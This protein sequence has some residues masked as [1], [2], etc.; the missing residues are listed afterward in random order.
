MPKSNKKAAAKKA[1]A[2]KAA[3]KK[4]AAAKKAAP[5]KKAAAKKAAPVARGAV[6]ADSSIPKWSGLSV[7]R[8]RSKQEKVSRDLMEAI[9]AGDPVRNK[10]LPDTPFTDVKDK[11]GREV[12]TGRHLVSLAGGQNAAQFEKAAKNASLKIASIESFDDLNQKG[13][14]QQILQEADGVILPKLEVAI[15]NPD[16]ESELSMLITH[17]STKDKFHYSE[18]ER[19]VYPAM[20]PKSKFQYSN[21]V[22]SAWGIQVINALNSTFS[23]KGIRIAVLDTGLDLDHPDFAGRIAGSKSFIENEDANDVVGHGSMSAGIAG[24]FRRTPDG[25]RYGVAFG[26]SLYIGKVI[27]KNSKGTDTSLL[28]GIE[29]A[30]QHKC[31]IINLS[32]VRAID[33]KQK[34]YSADYES[35]AAKALQNN[36]LIIAAAGNESDR[37]FNLIEPVAEP[38][39]CPSVMAVAALD[40]NIQVANFSCGGLFANGGQIDIAGPGVDIFSTSKEAGY[41][42]DSGTSA[43]APFVSGL[44]ALF[45]EKHPQATASEIWMKLIQNAKRLDINATDVGAGLA[46][47]L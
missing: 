5:K 7:I 18:P 41:A 44:A 2:K 34:G 30:L 42:T 28:D 17:P 24:G 12:Y 26:A 10:Q 19:F 27:N 43:A 33:P 31:H 25:M 47:F 21:N 36:C 29:W 13:L 20:P 16:K 9:G 35:T 22:T 37:E 4:K 23:G 11:H 39:N 14:S 1:A 8:N 40:G 6:Y 46:Y 45:W 3:P 15:I 38:A 32:V